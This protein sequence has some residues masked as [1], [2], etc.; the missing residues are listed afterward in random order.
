MDQVT[1]VLLMFCTVT[2]IYIYDIGTSVKAIFS[3]ISIKTFTVDIFKKHQEKIIKHQEEV[4]KNKST[5]MLKYCAFWIYSKYIFMAKLHT[6][7]LISSSILP[8][9]LYC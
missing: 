4:L 6:C 3:K 1:K 5:I 9:M 8:I 2:R 7:C